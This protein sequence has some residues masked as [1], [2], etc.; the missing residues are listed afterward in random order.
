MFTGVPM[1]NRVWVIDG[2]APLD[3][4]RIS[5]IADSTGS[6]TSVNYSAQQCTPADAAAIEASPQSNTNR[7]FPEWWSPA[8]VPAQAPQEDLFHKYVVTSVISNPETGG[9][10]DQSE[11][12]DYV[13]TG[14]PAWRYDTS[15]T[16][17]TAD[18][19]WSVFAGYNTIEIRK[20]SAANPSAQQTSDYTFYQGMDGD[21]ATPSGGTKTVYVT[22]STTLKDSLWFAGDTRETTTLLGVG[23]S[24]LSDTVNTPWASAVTANDGTNTARM[25]DIADTLTTA[26]LSTGAT[27]TTEVATTFDPTYGLPL[28]V[29][30]TSSDAPAQC[31]TTSYAPANTSAWLIGLPDEVAKVGADCANLATAV[32]PAAAISDIRTS[33]DGTAWG[34]AATIGDVTKTQTVDSYSGT[35]AGTAHWVTSSQTQYDSLGRPTQT[36]DVLGHTTSMSYTPAAGATPGS[37]PLTSETTTNTAPFSWTQTTNYNPAWGVETSS[38]DVNSE[39]TTATYDALGRRIAVWDPDNPQASNPSQPSV[40]YSYLLSTS[41]ANAIETETLEEGG[42]VDT[43]DL[44]DGLGRQVQ[45]QTPASGGG[46]QI[47]DTWYDSAGRTSGVNAPYWAAGNTASNTLFV[48]TSEAEIPSETVTQYDAAGRPTA[49]ILDSLGSERYRTT[50]SYSGV[51]RTDTTPPAGGTPTTSLTNSLGE[52]TT[53]IQYLASTP[54]A[55][56]TQETTTYGYD[57]SGQMTSMTDPAGNHWTWAFDVL[58]HQTSA[59]DPDTGTTSTTY[60]D[61]GNVLTSTDARG[62]V[63]A[64]TYDALNRKTN[65]YSTSTSGSLLDSWVYDT[66]A[67][68][69]LTS[70]TSYTGST[71]GHP[72][73]AYSN[74][75][76]GYNAGYNVTGTTVSIPT[77]APAFG[78]TSYTT[79]MAYDTGGA[80]SLVSYPAEGG[81]A[82]ERLRI[83]YDGFGTN[84]QLQEPARTSLP[85]TRR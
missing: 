41:S 38:T 62:Q 39:T 29:D 27:R 9:G 44:Y 58:G 77:G 32:Y 59:V 11:E 76:T 23:G 20:G 37:G 53:L 83:G 52:K 69:Q 84:R 34:T 16:T 45:T 65:E 80:P 48:P 64:Y 1:Q 35:T 56:A 2:L 36:T 54:L 25:T 71:P 70:S 18:R 19:T 47:S 3:K 5:S 6:V 68:G 60:D 40:G 15:P 30:S 21:R 51:D 74:T 43:F 33:Y 72:G 17:P 26:P 31:T 61:A 10:N 46:S 78:G 28:T 13:Y 82:A 22:G 81:L 7:C 75:V 67:K 8:V 42:V 57:P 49:Q 4:Y 12:T 66:L 14:T 73:L 50:T 79:S 55:T 24:V 85:V 63:L